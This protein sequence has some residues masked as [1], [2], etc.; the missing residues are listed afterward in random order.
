MNGVATKVTMLIGRVL[1]NTGISFDAGKIVENL[2]RMKRIGDFFIQNAA[3]TIMLTKKGTNENPVVYT[4][5]NK[6]NKKGNKN[7]A[8]YLC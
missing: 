8:K 5:C 1:D 4:S 7:L 6:G 3:D 2:P